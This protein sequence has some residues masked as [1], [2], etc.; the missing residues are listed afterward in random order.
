MAKRLALILAM[1]FLPA[2][3]KA[4]TIDMVSLAPTAFNVGRLLEPNATTPPTIFETVS[5]SFTWDINTNVLS[6]VVLTA[7][8][9][10]GMLPNTPE[11]LFTPFG[12]DLLNFVGPTSI[13]QIS[14][15]GAG[16]G[17]VIASDRLGTY[18]IPA[19]FVI[20]GGHEVS[21]GI[22]TV[23]RVAAP[24]P[25]SLL[26]LLIALGTFGL[27]ALVLPRITSP[28]GLRTRFA[29]AS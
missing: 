8:G 29:A 27:G 11:A 13:F 19:F 16:S 9:P 3:A 2:L 25:G 5:L 12:I 24:E 14:I 28:K 4:D 20:N 1:L 6:N 18:I 7:T 21:D 22:V 26:Q 15:E 10:G 23:S 17:T